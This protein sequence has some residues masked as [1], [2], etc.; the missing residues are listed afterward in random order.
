MRQLA[1]AIS[2]ALVLSNTS[3]WADEPGTPLRLI[4]TAPGAVDGPI[5]IDAMLAKGDGEFD[6]T[7]TG[8]SDALDQAVGYGEVS[9]HCVEVHCTLTINLGDDNLEV[10]V[11]VG[12]GGPADGHFK[13]TVDDKPLTGPVHFEPLTGPLPKDL[14]ALTAPDAVKAAELVDLLIWNGS[15][16]TFAARSGDELPDSFVR[17]SLAEWQAGAQL[18]STGLI[19]VK[20]MHTLREG[21]KAAQAKLGWTPLGSRAAG[22]SGGYPAALLPSVTTTG[23]EHHYASADGKALLVIALEPPMAD[24]AF[25]ALVEKQT[26]DNDARSGVGYDRSGP[27]MNLH[28]TEGGVVHVGRWHN[29]E[30]G[31]AWEMFTYPETQAETYEPLGAILPAV[32]T[33]DDSFKA[34]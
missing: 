10:A 9:G 4:G 18:L 24:E 21:A 27:D 20:D 25:D 22:W 32:F 7:I 28:Y 5:V 1:L 2:T 14:G 3:A 33:A 29:R 30:G 17:D 6:R 16:T 26:A 23:H 11:D 8:W 34:P 15:T 13:K 12:G 31:L 19:T